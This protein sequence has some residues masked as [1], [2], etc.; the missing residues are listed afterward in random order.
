[1]AEGQ[2][3]PS[4]LVNSGAHGI[5]LNG[6]FV[7]KAVTVKKTPLALLEPAPSD[8]AVPEGAEESGSVFVF[9]FF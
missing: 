2:I 8:P 3:P 4:E 7:I 6:V 9:V 1:V 5:V